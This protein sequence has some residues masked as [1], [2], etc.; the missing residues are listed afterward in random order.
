MSQP[1]TKKLKFIKV[2]KQELVETNGCSICSLGKLPTTDDGFE[3]YW[4]DVPAY[5]ARVFLFKHPTGDTITKLQTRPGTTIAL[6][7]QFLTE[8]TIFCRTCN[9][10]G[11]L[12][13]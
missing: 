9:V 7:E 8:A 3:A 10:P 13:G 6:L 12:N 4:D 11:V 5:N 1:K 2:K